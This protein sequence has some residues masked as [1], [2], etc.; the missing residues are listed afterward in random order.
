MSLS[1]HMKWQQLP[2]RLEWYAHTDLESTHRAQSLAHG[3][4]STNV[5]RPR[6]WI[7][8]KFILHLLFSELCSWGRGKETKRNFRSPQAAVICLH[9]SPRL[10]LQR[11]NQVPWGS[12]AC[13]QECRGGAQRRNCLGEGTVYDPVTLGIRKVP[14]CPLACPVQ[15]IWVQQ[16]CFYW[17][18][19]PWFKFQTAHDFILSSPAL[20]ANHYGFYRPRSP[21]LTHSIC[22]IFA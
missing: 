20:K 19:L 21:Q 10:S 16:T 2:H 8:K 13:S 6:N 7:F 14:S 12:K 4:Y 5:H 22:T 9:E 11:G 15:L 18:A 3:Q 17:P 1:K